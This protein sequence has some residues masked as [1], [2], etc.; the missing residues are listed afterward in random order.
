VGHATNGINPRQPRGQRFREGGRWVIRDFIYLDAERLRS[1]AAQL[2]GG[3]PEVS[4]RE[5]GH[6]T[7][8]A[9]SAEAGLWSFLRAQGELDYRYHRTST[10][11]RS[12]HHQVY[13][14]FEESLDGDGR[15][16]VIDDRFDYDAHWHPEHFADGAFVMIRGLVRCTDYSSAIEAL[17]AFPALIKSFKAIQLSNIKTAADSGSI[18]Q[19]EATAQRRELNDIEKVIKDGQVNQLTHLGRTLYKEGDVRIKVLPAGAPSDHILAGVGSFSGFLDSLGAGGITQSPPAA[20]WV[21]VGQ[22]SAAQHE[23]GLPP[24]PTGNAMEDAIE[25][26]GSSMRELMNVGTSAIF[27]AMEFVPLAIYRQTAT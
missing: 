22:I 6:E 8:G 19:E 16:E 12:M 2:L 13:S 24:M 18:G 5:T 11:T 15:I 25:G 10:E 26:M 4:S 9:G 17:A 27:P 21:T 14:L 7:G 3:V 20:Q 23:G 1:F